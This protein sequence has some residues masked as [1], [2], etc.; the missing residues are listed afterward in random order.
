[1]SKRLM[2]TT[3]ILVLNFLTY[4]FGMHKGVDLTALGTGL[5]LINAP[6]LPYL[7]AES[8]RPSL[9]KDEKTAKGEKAKKVQVND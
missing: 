9:S 5:A 3:G 1:M 6:V 2:I 7:G 4:W 8:F